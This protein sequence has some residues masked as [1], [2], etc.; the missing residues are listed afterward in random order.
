MESTSGFFEIEVQDDVLIVTP[1]GN[2]GEFDSEHISTGAKIVF[3]RLTHSNLSRLVFDF[4]KT[5]YFGS[6]ALGFFVR[7]WRTVSAR[8]GRMAFCNLS[9][10]EADI[11]KVTKLN[12]LWSICPTKADAVRS[13]RG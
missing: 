10:T 7:L 9:E 5:E 11:L 6:T 13:V 2:M 12:H 3:D 4:N 1:T 8:G